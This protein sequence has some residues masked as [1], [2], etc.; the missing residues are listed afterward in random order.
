MNTIPGYN[1]FLTQRRVLDSSAVR[2]SK[3]D[4]EKLFNH[5]S[6]E[7]MFGENEMSSLT[8]S[9][10]IWFDYLQWFLKTSKINPGYFIYPSFHPGFFA[11]YK[12]NELWIYPRPYYWSGSH[13]FILSISHSARGGFSYFTRA[14]MMP[15]HKACIAQCFAF[16]MPNNLNAYP[17]IDGRAYSLTMQKQY[18]KNLRKL[19]GMYPYI[20]GA[21]KSSENC[22]FSLL[23][24][25]SISPSKTAFPCM[26]T[27]ALGRWQTSAQSLAQSNLSDSKKRLLITSLMILLRQ[28]AFDHLIHGDC[29]LSNII[30]VGHILPVLIDA[31]TL[32]KIGKRK[33]S[34]T[35]EHRIATFPD[36]AFPECHQTKDSDL[37][38]VCCHLLL[39]FLIPDT[40]QQAQ[41]STIFQ[42]MRRTLDLQTNT[43]LR[44]M[45]QL[46]YEKLR[47]DNYQ[48]LYRVLEK[49]NYS[50]IIKPPMLS[51]IL[52][53]IHPLVAVRPCLNDFLS[54]K[55]ILRQSLT[56]I[57]D[58][59][60]QYPDDFVK[61]DMLRIHCKR[62][63]AIDP[64]RWMNQS[65]PLLLM[66][67]LAAVHDQ[68]VLWS[69][70][71]HH[72]S[73]CLRMLGKD[74]SLIELE[75]MRLEYDA[76]FFDRASIDYL[77]Q[78]LMFSTGDSLLSSILYEVAEESVSAIDGEDDPD[79]S[80]FGDTL[81][82]LFY[83][84]D[85][86]PSDLSC[87]AFTQPCGLL[88]V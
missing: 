6:S 19:L 66:G 79:C 39:F 42:L 16:I 49:I 20:N 3:R 53:F 72:W 7:S 4:C 44:L 50:Q 81:S 73:Q 2:V 10:I 47:F 36:Y 43:H 80:F 52:S 85:T 40:K 24:L 22:S 12:G 37:F 71:K 27:S 57:Y 46:D 28:L 77:L 65:S 67:S 30:M 86:E 84:V 25:P 56:D 33:K 74:A 48:S 88:R 34:I 15:N 76:W 63:L 21:V 32:V 83:H 5:L 11:Y 29:S 38:S 82:K 54:D 58:I 14:F 87:C 35:R 51:Y 23:G 78:E 62:I 75:S 55:R 1:G 8:P 68:T 9:H 45:P 59:I 69:A 64:S 18:K 26:L 70:R 17:F 61:K 13:L 60:D 31:S 41:I